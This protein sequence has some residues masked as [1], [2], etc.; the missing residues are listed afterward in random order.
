MISELSVWAAT[1]FPPAATLLVMLYIIWQDPY[2]E[3][4]NRTTMFWIVLLVFGILILDCLNALFLIRVLVPERIVADIC[5]YAARP[6]AIVLLLRVLEPEK[7]HPVCWVLLGV[8]A[9]I[10]MTALFSP[11]CFTLDPTGFFIRGPLGYTSH[12]VSGILLA[13]MTW[14]SVRISCRSRRRE[15]L[16]PVLS[17]LLIVASVVLDSQ[18]SDVPVP[19]VTCAM[20]LCCML[21]YIWLHLRFVR[22]HENA[23]MAEQR[24]RIMMSQIQ[25][26][27]LYNT[28]STIQALCRT[29]PEKA[30]DVTERFGTYLR[31]NLDALRQ[32]QCI[33]V[34]KELEHTRVYTEI[35]ALRFPNVH[36][37]YE[38]RD[39][40][41]SLPALTIQPLVENAIRHG[42][43]IR[44]DGRVRIQTRDAEDFHE[45]TITDNGIGFDALSAENA[46][47]A[48]IG[49]RNVKERLAAQ[50]GSSMEIVSEADHGTTITIRI[51]K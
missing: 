51:P 5:C 26:H 9:A 49:L 2:I 44:E 8:N 48:H 12:I 28:L 16:L 15:S 13:Y 7:R 40:G 30:F 11:I 14:V 10:H 6:L 3:K 23:L 34:E 24:I 20:V 27:F 37:E 4:K 33:P 31:Q 46:N 36:V 21:Y 22:A 32:T 29:D 50:C 1:I 43:R 35:E 47:D 17:V 39:T 38:I 41:F 42:V 19:M 45:I 25:P 18:I